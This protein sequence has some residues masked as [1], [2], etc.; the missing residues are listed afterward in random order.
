V[1]Y[2]TKSNPLMQI[3]IW[4]AMTSIFRYKNK[5]LIEVAMWGSTRGMAKN[6]SSSS[7][8]YNALN[9]ILTFCDNFIY[10]YSAFS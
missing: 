8:L 4:F 6:M 9:D 1:L 5:L 2:A 7:K 10:L 3:G